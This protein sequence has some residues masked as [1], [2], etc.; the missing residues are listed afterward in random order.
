MP[1]ETTNPTDQVR[2]LIPSALSTYKDALTGKKVSVAA[3]KAATNILKTHGLIGDSAAGPTNK[4]LKICFIEIGT[5]EDGN[6]IIL[7]PRSERN[8]DGSLPN[9]GSNPDSTE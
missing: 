3:E 6:P 8:R 4:K 7:G 2:D 9:R 1:E 5:D